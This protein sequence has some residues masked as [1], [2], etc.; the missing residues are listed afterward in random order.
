MYAV[1]D[2]WIQITTLLSSLLGDLSEPV[3]HIQPSLHHRAGKRRTKYTTL[4]VLGGREEYILDIAIS[5]YSCWTPSQ[6]QKEQNTPTYRQGKDFC[7]LEQ[8]PRECKKTCLCKPKKGGGPPQNELMETRYAPGGTEFESQLKVNKSSCLMSAHRILEGVPNCFILP[9][10]LVC[11]LTLCSY[12]RQLI[13]LTIILCPE[14]RN[15]LCCQTSRW[16]LFWCFS[17]GLKEL[18][19]IPGQEC[20]L[21]STL[22]MRAV[23]ESCC[24]ASCAWCM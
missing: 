16:D 23:M 18:G 21:W 15:E 22:V 5:N 3:T 11:L 20:N 12:K 2:N 14:A 24:L 4:K 10:S 13:M 6:L 17:G 9:L 19:S 1:W 8:L 7:V